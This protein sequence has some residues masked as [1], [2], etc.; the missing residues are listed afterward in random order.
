MSFVVIDLW[1]E[2]LFILTLTVSM[3]RATL[4]SLPTHC[5]GRLL[6]PKQKTGNKA[7]AVCVLMDQLN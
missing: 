6:W 2:I 5:Q 4:V 3:P 7:I 1:Q